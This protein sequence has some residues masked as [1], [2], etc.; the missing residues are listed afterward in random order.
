MLALSEQRVKQVLGTM[1][2]RLNIPFLWLTASW[3][4]S[5][6]KRLFHGFYFIYHCAGVEFT[7]AIRK[8]ISLNK[9]VNAK[10]LSK[11]GNYKKIQ[12]LYCSATIR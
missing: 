9:T 3:H 2:Y 11:K 4:Q 5:R 6:R 7:F 8:E 12:A 10:I 1:F